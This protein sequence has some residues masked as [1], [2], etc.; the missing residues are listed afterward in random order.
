MDESIST[1]NPA[2]TENMECLIVKTCTPDT[3]KN[4]GCVARSRYIITLCFHFPAIKT[5]WATFQTKNSIRRAPAGSALFKSCTEAI[6]RAPQNLYLSSSWE[7]NEALRRTE[8]N[9]DGANV[10]AAVVGEKAQLGTKQRYK[11]WRNQAWSY[12]HY[13]V[14]LVWKTKLVNQSIENST[15]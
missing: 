14:M 4:S 10:G 6:K 9:F 2:I 12:S 13:R 7:R 8:V 1:V 15:K 11:Q 5:V 3:D